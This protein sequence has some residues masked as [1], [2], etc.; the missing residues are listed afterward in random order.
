MWVLSASPSILLPTQEEVGNILVDHFKRLYIDGVDVPP[1]P[2]VPRYSGE[3]D[4]DLILLDGHHRA[5]AAYSIGKLVPVVAYEDDRDIAAAE[6]CAGR[7]RDMCS[8]QN[9]I[10][11]YDLHWKPLMEQFNIRSIGDIA[12]V[13][14]ST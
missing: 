7:L 9:V 10:T 8:Y 4:H 13:D 11:T 5:Y 14:T 12:L 3:L 6:A 1:I 2:V